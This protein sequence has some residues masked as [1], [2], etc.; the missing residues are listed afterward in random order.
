ML[1]LRDESRR[2]INIVPRTHRNANDHDEVRTTSYVDV[3]GPDGSE[4]HGCR[5]RVE[6][7]TQRKLTG[8]QAQAGEE[9]PCSRCWRH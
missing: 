7:D 9:G 6:H 8:Q 3:F 2:L 1:S 4:V 5:Y